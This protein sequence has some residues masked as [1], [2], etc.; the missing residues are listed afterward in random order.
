MTSYRAGVILRCANILMFALWLYR[1]SL[2][3]VGGVSTAAFAGLGAY[4]LA[5]A[6][7]ALLRREIS[8]RREAAFLAGDI[9]ALSL[10]VA[11]TRTWISEVHLAFL[12]P[13]ILAS[14]RLSPRLAAAIGLFA[15]AC[16]LGLGALTQLPLPAVFTYRAAT[17]LL[18]A[19]AA[20][21][22]SAASLH[23]SSGSTLR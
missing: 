19:L 21:L 18:A 5:N 4:L 23:R 22:F 13:V 9:A 20:H 7:Q 1:M 8:P 16:V 14:L 10:A 3:G 12:A 11:A 2:G 6:A 17:L 15:G